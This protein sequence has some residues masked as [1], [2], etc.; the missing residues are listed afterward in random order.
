VYHKKI[1]LIKKETSPKPDIPNSL[2][3]SILGIKFKPID[4]GISSNCL[5]NPNKKAKRRPE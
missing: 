3:K 1:Y 4:I 2:K 5:S